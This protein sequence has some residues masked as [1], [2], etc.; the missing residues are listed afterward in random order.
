[1]SYNA[2]VKGIWLF[3]TSL[4][5]EINN[6]SFSMPNYLAS[7]TQYQQY[8]LASDSVQTKYGILFEEGHYLVANGVVLADA[9]SLRNFNI[10]FWWYSPS[11]VGYTRHA[12]TRNL[13]TKVAPIL[14]QAESYTY[15]NQELITNGSGE[16]IVSEVAASSTQNAIQL[17]ICNGSNEPTHRYVSQPY[18]PGLRQVY[19]DYGTNATSDA[20]I[21]KIFIDGNLAEYQGPSTNFS[22]TSSNLYLNRIYHGYSAHK[23]CQNGSYLSELVIRGGSDTTDEDANKVYKFGWQSITESTQ[24]DYQYAYLGIGYYQPSTVTTNQIFSEGGNIVVAR[25]NGDILKGYRPIWDNEY[26][27]KDQ[28]DVNLLNATDSTKVERLSTGSGIKITGTTIKI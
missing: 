14:A 1:M 23:T 13:T 8:N 10:S 18:S 4:E 12:V 27:Y 6:N 16:I 9:S 26:Q 28:V 11:A 22:L 2:L 20:S 5:D 25:S 15:A 21:I 3:N 7:Y 24:Y 19:I 17:E